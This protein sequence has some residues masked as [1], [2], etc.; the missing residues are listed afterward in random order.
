[1]AGINLILKIEFNAIDADFHR[2][3]VATAPGE[4]LLMGRRAVRN[5]T[6]LQF[7][8]LILKKTNKNC[9]HQSC[10]S[11]TQNTVIEAKLKSKQTKESQS[12]YGRARSTNAQ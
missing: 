1:M 10:P 12:Q 8:T 6:Q 11:F 5:W 7:F 4:K 9:R 3:M 2:A